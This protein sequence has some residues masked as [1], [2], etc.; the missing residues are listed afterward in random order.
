MRLLPR[1]LLWR[2]FLTLATLMVLS[3]LVWFQIFNLYERTPRAHG[4]AQ[5]IASVVNLTRAAL[6]SAEPAKR[7]ELLEELSAREGLRIFPAEDNEVVDPLPDSSFFALMVPELREK[8]DKKTRVAFGRNNVPGFWVSFTIDDDEYW[9]MVPRDRFNRLVPVEWLGWGAAALLLSLVGT[10]LIVF[11]ITRPL[12]AMSHAARAIGRGETPAPLPEKDPIE[13][14]LVSR[15]FNQMTRDLSQLDAD[16]ALI[17]AGISHDLRTP[18]SRMRLCVEMMPEDDFTRDGMVADIEEIDRTIGQFLD[19]ARQNTG[20]APDILP[21]DELAEDVAARYARRGRDV[22]YSAEENL[23]PPLPLRSEAV[24]RVLANL[25]ENALKY[26]GDG[27]ITVKAR[28]E[29][30]SALLEVWDQGPGIPEDQLERVKRPFARLESAR[31]N[32]AG[33][34]LGLAIVDRVARCHGGQFQLLGRPQLDGKSG[35]VARVSFPL[36]PE[37][38]ADASKQTSG[39][40]A[41]ETGLMG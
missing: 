27:P 35:L 37:K 6:M 13:I 7:M 19:F 30:D 5:L 16:R 39:N 8:L 4:A 28:R 14:A 9:I 24:R 21:L 33:A 40:G 22:S 34:G 36:A 25:I 26:A 31:S 2:T 1:S 18:L 20:E 3:V 12:K 17:L 29:G 11:R 15:A 32:T 23:P 10:Y 41:G 38:N